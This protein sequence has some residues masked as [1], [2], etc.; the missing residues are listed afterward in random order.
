MSETVIERIPVPILYTN[1][2]GET[3]VRKIV[4]HTRHPVVSGK[5]SLWFGST[6]W[7]PEPQWLLTAVDVEKGA[8]RDWALS[9]IKAWG[10]EAVSAALA[11]TAGAGAGAWVTVPRDAPEAMWGGLARQI[12]MWCRFGQPTGKA[13]FQHLKS[14]GYEIPAWL[15]E[16]VEDVDYVPPKGTI[17]VIIY[18]AMIE[19]APAV[20]ASPRSGAGGFKL[21]VTDDW[22]RRKVAEEPDLETEAGILHPEAPAPAEHGVE[23]RD[24]VG[25]ARLQAASERAIYGDDAGELYDELAD[26]IV[27]ALSQADAAG[28]SERAVDGGRVLAGAFDAAQHWQL[29]EETRAY[30]REIDLATVQP[31]D[32]RLNTV[33]GPAGPAVGMDGYGSQ[34]RPLS[35]APSPAPAQ[36]PS[37]SDAEG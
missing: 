15:R 33:V 11:S 7:H 16:E 18:R 10:E 21:A 32:P 26:A 2:R 17:A 30:L 29:S 20:P 37:T 19:A 6:Q 25:R 4:P 27:S 22:M 1:W 13:L 36:S 31:G 28:R 14:S 3:A 12:V 9:G 24:L 34:A 8:V 35:P 5:P 23:I